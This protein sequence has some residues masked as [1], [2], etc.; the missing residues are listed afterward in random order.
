M[1]KSQRHLLIPANKKSLTLRRGIFQHTIA[2]GRKVTVR[3]GTNK[4]W[5]KFLSSYFHKSS[6]PKIR[7]I[8]LKEVCVI[9]V[10]T[11]KTCLAFV[12]LNCPPLPWLFNGKTMTE[13]ILKLLPT[14]TNEIMP[15]LNHATLVIYDR[16]IYP[17]ETPV[18]KLLKQAAE[19]NVNPNIE[20]LMKEPL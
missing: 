1:E 5:K 17:A 4:K 2:D 20:A 13:F 9:E 18:G 12:F 11:E 8:S 14:L 3:K 10:P 7:D 6:V 16:R 19:N 15:L